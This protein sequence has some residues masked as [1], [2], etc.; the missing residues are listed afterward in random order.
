[1]RKYP[2][3]EKVDY[4]N[5][6]IMKMV[7]GQESVLVIEG[8]NAEDKSLFIFDCKAEEVLF[9]LPISCLNSFHS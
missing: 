3:A 6:T 9:V 8:S 2:I 1:M 5:I 4:D 7:T